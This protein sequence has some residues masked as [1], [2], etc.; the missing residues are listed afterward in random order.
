MGKKR[1]RLMYVYI[2]KLSVDAESHRRSSLLG[3][4]AAGGTGGGAANQK[5]HMAAAED[6]VVRAFDL[7]L[8]RDFPALS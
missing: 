5:R 1:E 8:D 3:G 4:N 2:E 6:P 7:T